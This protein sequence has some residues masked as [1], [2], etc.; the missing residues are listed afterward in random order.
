MISSGYS[1]INLAEKKKSN[2]L[3]TNISM[4]SKEP[5]ESLVVG[6]VTIK[7]A[8]E[9]L[10]KSGLNKRAIIVLIQDRTKLS[11][12]HIEKTLDALCHLEKWYTNYTD[13]KE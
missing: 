2:L 11:K 6:I 1:E 7:K 8:M 5:G 3:L 4:G 9:E 13:T 10:M 12:E